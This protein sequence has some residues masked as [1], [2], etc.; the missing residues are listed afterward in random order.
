MKVNGCETFDVSIGCAGVF[1]EGKYPR[2][3]ASR[4]M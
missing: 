1:G 4:V 3:Q 2:A